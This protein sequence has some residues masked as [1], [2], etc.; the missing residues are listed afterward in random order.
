MFAIIDI[1]TTGGS[2]KLEKITEIAVYLHDGEKITGEYNTLVNPE[3]NIPYYITNLTGITNEMVENAPRFYEIAKQIVELTEGRIF[4]AHNARFDYSFIRQEFKSLGYNFKRS[5]L[6]TVSLSRRLFPGYRSYSLGNICRELKIEINDR[7]RAAGDALATVKLFELLTERDRELSFGNSGLIRNTRLS[8]LNPHLDLSKIESIPDEPGIYYFYNDRGDL[9]YIG[10]SRNLQQRISTHLSN[11]TT[12]RAMEM[13]DLIADIS[14]ELTGSELI[15]L[16]R[17][18][19]EIKDN[20]PVYNRAQR[21]SSF[22]WGIYTSTDKN[23]YINFCLL[24]V[25]TEETPLSVFSSRERARSK[26]ESLTGKYDLCQKLAGLY[27]CDGPCFQHHVGICRGACCGKE[28]A[29]DYNLR[30]TKAIEEFVF[31][32]RNFFII[33]RG[34]NDEEK[35]AVR[36]INGKYSGYGYFNINDIGFGLTAVHDC[37]KTSPDN[38]DIQVIL[39]QYLRTNKVEKII[40]F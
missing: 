5:I 4:V 19:Y 8:K 35:S 21:R 33:D 28:T 2:A 23:G 36:I 20:K 13:R 26:L 40:E 22:Q 6:D 31:S 30:A 37:I 29:A 25:S 17:E 18:S 16:L 10:K 39:K 14:W 38:R 32:R 7:H 12:N 15:A 24:P 27:K 3:R 34:R 9:I 1:E 11:N